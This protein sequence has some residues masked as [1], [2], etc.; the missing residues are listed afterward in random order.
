MPLYSE[1]MAEGAGD[2]IEGVFGTAQFNEKLDDAGSLAFIK[3]FTDEYGRPPSQAAH[4]V[5][6]HILLYA[7]AVER[8]GT[9]YPPEVIKT[10]EDFEFEGTGPNKTLYRGT[11]HQAFH[12]IFVV[13]GKAASARQNEFDRLEIVRQVPREEVTYP[14]DIPAFGG[15]EADLGPY[16][17]AA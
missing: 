11:D 10:L 5:Y 15:P 16:E 1:L 2:N 7:D 17:P 12:D 13:R 9:F 4:T 14:E 6:T 8:A 3:P